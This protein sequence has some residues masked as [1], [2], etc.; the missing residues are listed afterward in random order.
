MIERY[1]DYLLR[2]RKLVLLV[3]GLLTVGA[4][5]AIGTRAT[6]GTSLR[7]LFLGETPAY[8]E[9]LKRV[10]SFRNDDVVILALADVD[11]LDPE[12]IGH[13]RGAVEK[14]KALERV[15]EVHIASPGTPAPAPPGVAEFEDEFAE[16]EAD[17]LEAQPDAKQVTGEVG[18]VESVVSAQKLYLRDGI[19]RADEYAELAEQTDAAGRAALA[20]EL[21]G[22]DLLAGLTI[23]KDGRHTT[24]LVELVSDEDRPVESGPKLVDDITDLFVAEGFAPDKIHRVGYLAALSASTAAT[25]HAIET[26]FPIVTVVL[27]LVV[28][29]LFRRLW[30]VALSTGVSLTAVTWTMGFSVLIDPQITIMHGMIPTVVMVVG[31]SDIIHLCSAYLL[32]LAAGHPKDKAIRLSCVDVGKAC[33]YTSA[34]TFVGFIGMSFVPTPAFRQ[35]GVALGFGVA[36]ALVLAVTV[37]PIAFSYMRKPKAWRAGAT[38]RVQGGLDRVLSGLS[39]LAARHP[40]PIIVGF[41]AVLAVAIVGVERLHIET[42]FND[43]FDEESRLR[44]DIAF[45]EKNFDAANFLDVFIE[46]PERDGLHDPELVA[47]L[48]RFQE[49]AQ[50]LPNVVRVQSYADLLARVH[51]LLRQ[52]NPEIAAAPDTAAM[53]A[54]WLFLFEDGGGEGLHRLMDFERKTALVSVRLEDEAVRHAAE[55]GDAIAALA[56]KHLGDDVKIEPSGVSYLFG[57]WL[58]S[59]VSGQARGLGFTTIIITFMMMFGLRSFRLGAWSMIPNL[60]PLL[61]LGGY[62]GLA[63][64]RVDSDTLSLAMLAIGIGVDDTIHFLMR[65]RIEAARTADRAVAL[66]RT[67]DFA[68]RAIVMTTVT[69]CAG[70][71]P[72]ALSDYY[73]VHVFGTLLPMTITVALL[74][75]LLLVPA[76]AQVGLL[77]PRQAR[78]T[79]PPLT[80][81]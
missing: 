63:Y 81:G 59:I 33:L 5:V 26:L 35:L 55:T 21:A 64:D 69:L 2:R 60:L 57:N 11:P 9:Y 72:L 48:T 23:S 19:L 18:R 14:V 50:H 37:V 62:L 30:P 51:A 10:E 38:S 8:Y 68:G 7:K 54:Q 71:A 32:E 56:R 46:T 3:V 77:A 58:D 15:G 28:F 44:T 20:V 49:E 65:F 6:F 73:S 40:W 66:K 78:A 74:A 12:T 67:F 36:A 16:L 22:D 76:L 45:F 25:I 41:V 75:D 43:R 27:L 4:G 47:K 13:I 80:A 29:L 24:V 42:A 52:V 1:V 53:V 79:S 31:F 70:F 39:W 61:C 34:T 17:A